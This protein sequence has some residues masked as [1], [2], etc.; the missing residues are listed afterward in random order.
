MADG[1][2]THATQNR[3]AM[4]A[5][6]E[7]ALREA[8]PDDVVG[9]GITADIRADFLTELRNR[10]H[11][12]GHETDRHHE[13]LRLVDEMARYAGVEVCPACG[14]YQR[15]GMS[16]PWPGIMEIVANPLRPTP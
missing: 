7:G 10:H 4:Y 2:G 9:L 12:V 8:L 15:H 13:L 1:Q 5:A 3:L 6:V 11:V 16:C 14:L